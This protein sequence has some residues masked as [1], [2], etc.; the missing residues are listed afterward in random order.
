MNEDK[1]PVG[2]SS[3]LLGQEV[4]YNG[5]HKRSRVCLNSFAR[6]FDYRAFCPEV[7]IGMGVPREAIRL[8]DAPDSPR[9]VGTKTPTLDVTDELYAYGLEVGRTSEDL[10][11][12]ILMKN[13]PSC[14][15]YS[16]KVYRGESPLP[17][18][19]AGMFV[20]GLR[21]TQPLLPME[22]EGR[23]NDPVL[24]ENFIAAVY[25]YH[26]WRTNF[27]VEPSPNA[28]VAF[29]SKYKFLVMAH[30]QAPYKQLGRI[31]A[32]AGASG[33]D[34]RIN[35]YIAALMETL[36][37]PA[38]RKGHVNTLFHILGYLRDTV[39]GDVREDIHRVIESYRLGFVN[40]S[41]P[42]TM[43]HHY[44]KRFGSDYVNEQAY[45]NP[46]SEELGLRNTI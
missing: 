8:V 25:A 26:D 18:K 34:E 29:H 32:D 31:V 41:V 45:L 33:F 22:E 19:H 30:G 3:C 12:Y 42:A 38:S 10:S 5:G 17:G 7:A 40:L 36:K 39:A 27:M 16:A 13:S 14:G 23:L 44:V 43:L 15:L 2:I 1:I 4:R 21:H 9:V 46:Y 20:R 6:V 28:L 35:A 11:G 24:R 37:K